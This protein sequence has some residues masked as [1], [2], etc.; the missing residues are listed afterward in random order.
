M[1]L[2]STSSDSSASKRMPL[3]VPAVPTGMKTGVWICPRRVV[4]TPARASPSCASIWK[5]S[6]L[7]IMVENKNFLAQRRKDAEENSILSLR[8]CAFA[9]E[10]LM[11]LHDSQGR[12]EE[13]KLL[14]QAIHQIP[15]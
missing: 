7:E 4:N 12:R 1:I 10:L 9:R 3:T 6:A 2:A 15:L 11:L 5:R 14:A 13:I 8:L